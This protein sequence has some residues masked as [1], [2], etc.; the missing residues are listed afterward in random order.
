MNL[1]NKS[2]RQFKLMKIVINQMR[3]ICRNK[4][5]RNTFMLQHKCLYN[6]KK[7]IME[8]ITTIKQD[9]NCQKKI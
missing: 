9:M 8:T 7:S 5:L 1:M 2:N 4:N 3:K 6:L